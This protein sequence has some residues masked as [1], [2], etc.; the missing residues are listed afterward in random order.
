MSTAD[1]LP[2]KRVDEDANHF[3]DDYARGS[4][5]LTAADTLRYTGRLAAGGEGMPA[6]RHGGSQCVCRAPRSP[7]SKLELDEGLDWLAPAVAE[8]GASL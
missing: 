4:E 7:V 8:A 2:E 5:P 1:Y 6:P 3:S